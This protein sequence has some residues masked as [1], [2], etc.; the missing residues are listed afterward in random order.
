MAL[1]NFSVVDIAGRGLDHLYLAAKRVEKGIP[2][3]KAAESLAKAVKP[4]ENV[5]IGTGFT[6][7]KVQRGETDGPPGAAVLAK[8]LETIGVRTIIV[9]DPH[10]V[11]IVESVCSEIEV[12]NCEVEPFSL[13]L[14]QVREDTERILR[15]YRPSALIAIERPGWNRKQV[16][17]TLSGLDISGHC[18]PLDILFEEAFRRKILTIGIGDGGNE[19]GMGK[20]RESVEEFI[21]NGR[22]CKC[23]CGGGIAAVTR[24]SHVLVGGTSN[25]ASYALTASYALLTNSS[26]THDGVE[27]A[28]LIY[29]AF[30]AG[31]VDGITG[32]NTPSVDTI[33][34]EVN[35]KLADVIYLLAEQHQ[36]RVSISSV[37]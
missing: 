4:K 32:H 27:E 18:S 7:A 28:K 30:E 21:P 9:T 17:H 23:P 37:D 34:V 26:Y 14:G 12:E 11:E 29:A 6:I 24:T 15:D 16:Y 1:S 19:I 5:I 3:L 2:C 33:P 10:N 22:T 35:S 13:D 31:A 36:H 20:I 8:Q 25:L